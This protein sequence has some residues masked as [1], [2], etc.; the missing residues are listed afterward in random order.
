MTALIQ[1][2][3]VVN[4]NVNV[5]AESQASGEGAE[6]ANSGGPA[7]LEKCGKDGAMETIIGVFQDA[8]VGRRRKL[9]I[10]GVYILTRTEHV[11]MSYLDQIDFC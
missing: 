1:G 7:A 5:N 11:A 4:V 3:R 9:K 8:R 2:D 6:C 10:L